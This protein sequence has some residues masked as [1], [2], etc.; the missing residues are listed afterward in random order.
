MRRTICF[1]LLLLFI[2]AG[3]V[4]AFDFDFDDLFN[5]DLLIEVEE[6]VDAKTGRSP[7]GSG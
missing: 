3:M 1:I 7:V 5:D 6:T 2:P 4:S